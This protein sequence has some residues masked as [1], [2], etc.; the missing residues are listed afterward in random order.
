MR[1]LLTRSMVAFEVLR[2]LAR[3]QQ[4]QQVLAPVVFTSALALGDLYEPSVREQFGEP[5]W[6][7][8]QGPQ[9]WLDAQITEYS[10]GILLNWDV[11]DDV[12]IE[13]VVAAMF[14]YFRAQIDRLLEAPEAWHLPLQELAPVAPIEPQQVR[15]PPVPEP[16][17]A[18]VFAQASHAPD[19]VALLW[20]DGDAMSYGELAE[21]AL[22]VAAFLHASDVRPGDSVAITMPEGMAADCCGARRAGGRLHLCAM[23]DRPATVAT[24]SDLSECGRAAGAGR[25]KWACV[26][27][28]AGPP[29]C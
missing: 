29:V 4:G 27:G 28:A 9:V 10:G 8:S 17:F 6:S 24:R 26:G 23:R 16:L 13:G 22:R 18:R 15:R 3:R 20:G 19:A 12:F 25:D 7:I 11:R 5:V 14:A 2:D 21:R 1:P